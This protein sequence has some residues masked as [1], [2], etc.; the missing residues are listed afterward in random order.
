MG[1]FEGRG[2]REAIFWT[3][4]RGHRG[5]EPKDGS[6]TAAN[7]ACFWRVFDHFRI[8]VAKFGCIIMSPL[9]KWVD[10][11]KEE[12]EEGTKLERR[13]KAKKAHQKCENFNTLSQFS[14]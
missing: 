7:C 9:H 3:A 14:Q 10:E 4:A 13:R 6:C 2:R 5:E 11:E 1:E 8:K 12:M